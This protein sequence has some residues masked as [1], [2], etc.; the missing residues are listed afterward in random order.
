MAYF[1]IVNN[2]GSTVGPYNGQ[3]ITTGNSLNVNLPAIGYTND[4]VLYGD[5][6]QGIS[7]IS[8]GAATLDASSGVDYLIS[9][10][11][12][13]LPM[14]PASTSPVVSDPSLVVAL[15]P[16]SAIP[17]GAATSALQTSILTQLTDV[18]DA[19][20]SSTATLGSGATF[21]GTGTDTLGYGVIT[22]SAAS[23]VAGSFVLEWS[24]NNS[25][26]F[27]DGDTY[28]V[29]AGSALKGNTYGP[30]LRY[31]RVR[32][33]NGGT[34]QGS[35]TLQCILK[36]HATKP[37]SHKAS[38]AFN[39]STDLEG[40]KAI[41]SGK[42]NDGTY[43]NAT[44]TN[45]NNL[46]LALQEVDTAL[47]ESGLLGV[48]AIANGG[49]T[50]AALTVGTSAVELKV[51]GSALTNRVNAT[52]YNNSLVPIYWGYTSGVTTSTGT[53]IAPGQPW[54]WDCG[55]STTI[56]LI[57]GTSSNNTRITEAAG[58]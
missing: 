57:A 12:A 21:L 9:L 39:D 8:V 52:C 42:R 36:A 22:V 56:Y 28:D 40:V 14:V 31:Y 30:K 47:Q 7:S 34:G 49:G 35:F 45:G 18:V 17:T 33:V 48:A 6:N 2:I 10:E 50:Q 53:P 58:T 41:M 26:W 51:G 32:Y 46:K 20:N 19:N 25:T 38:E 4:P 23:N 54:S 44:L 27:S 1:T 11:M 13:S 29:A 37:S 15:S 55:P 24:A 5:I 3:Y 16:N 43:G